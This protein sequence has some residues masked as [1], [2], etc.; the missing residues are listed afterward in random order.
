MRSRLATLGFGLVL[1]AAALGPARPALAGDLLPPP[2]IYQVLCLAELDVIEVRRLDVAPETAR[3]VVARHDEALAAANNLYVPDWH[4]HLDRAPNEP[5]YG[6]APTIF[7]CKFSVGPAELVLLPEPIEEHAN[8]IAV[9]L[10]LKN[11]VIVDDVPFRLCAHGGPIT[12]LIYH[13][14]EEYVFLEGSFRSYQSA[15]PEAQAS[16]ATYSRRANIDRFGG[17]SLR[18]EATGGH[19]I[20]FGGLRT[21][22]LDYAGVDF[23]RIAAGARKCRFAGPGSPDARLQSPAANDDRR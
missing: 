21:S 9:T 5:G 15:S 19:S 7:K 13:A 23:A 20:R 8:S 17:I 1:L 10:K 14:A 4:A 2:E 6:I 11:K 12:R 3:E 16:L 22:D 18:N